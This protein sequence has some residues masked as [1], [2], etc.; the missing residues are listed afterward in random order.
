[1]ALLVAYPA[2]EVKR[3]V[4]FRANDAKRLKNYAR[5][6]GRPSK[7]HGGKTPHRIIFIKEWADKYSLEP[8]DFIEN[9]GVDKSTV[10][11]WF[12]G[13]VPAEANLPRLAAY[14]HCDV[15]DL[16]RPPGDDWLRRFF[17]HR[18]E[19]E[20]EHIKRA[21]ETTFPLKTGANTRK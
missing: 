18:A 11:R 16:F 10:S 7:I 19:E 2:T 8:A 9:L 3:R 12:A 21:M 15:A 5:V 20:I 1:M 4:A 13:Q 17:Q 6:M 14:L